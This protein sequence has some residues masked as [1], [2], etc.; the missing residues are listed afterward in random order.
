MTLY[1]YYELLVN[2]MFIIP[3]FVCQATH[4]KKKK[5]SAI[6]IFEF[7][8]R[9]VESHD[10]RLAG[11]WFVGFSLCVMITVDSLFILFTLKINLHI[12]QFYYIKK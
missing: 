2:E 11:L 3:I 6:L 10:T 5:K 4:V 8:L 9:A 7:T 1:Y 12:Y